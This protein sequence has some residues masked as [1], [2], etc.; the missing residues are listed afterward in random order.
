MSIVEENIEGN[1]T[2]KYK[3]LSREEL[4]DRLSALLEVFKVY[5]DICSDINWRDISCDLPSMSE[6]IIRID[7]RK[8]YFNIFHENT[9]MNE[10][11]EAALLAYWI[12]KFRP[13]SWRIKMSKR[14]EKINE[15]F[16]I[17]IM[18]SA[19]KEE[20]NRDS[21]KEFCIS[22]DYIRKLSYAFRYWDI[23]K[24]AMMLISESLSEAMRYRKAK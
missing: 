24:E 17:F 6:I 4:Y 14:Y 21:E 19:I 20:T 9:E 2:Y 13:F 16:A 23:S 5:V 10:A 7:K 12:I 1:I 22:S 18:L 11:K 3:E 8:D 15:I